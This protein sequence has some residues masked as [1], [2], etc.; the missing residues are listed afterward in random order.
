[1]KFF[2]DKVIKSQVQT[3]CFTKLD[4]YELK[5]KGAFDA[6][7]NLYENNKGEDSD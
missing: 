7:K 3:A 2:F 4:D 5:I 1:M 6:L